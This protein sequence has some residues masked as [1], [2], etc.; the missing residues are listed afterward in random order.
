MPRF[1]VGFPGTNV[2]E[3][4]SYSCFECAFRFI[5]VKY[6]AW[7]QRQLHALS[8]GEQFPCKE[9]VLQSCDNSDSDSSSSDDDPNSHPQAISGK[10]DDS[11]T[12]SDLENHSQ[13]TVLSVEKPCVKKCGD[14]DTHDDTHDDTSNGGC[15][16]DDDASKSDSP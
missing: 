2:H 6:T 7:Q 9:D 10:D 15:L 16:G 5:A 1:S 13:S 3:R 4:T 8:S 14:G 11:V 12:V